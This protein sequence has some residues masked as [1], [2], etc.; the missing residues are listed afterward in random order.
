MRAIT[1]NA[2]PPS[3]TAHRLTPHCDYDNYPD[4]A[5]LRNALVTE[6]RGL[7]CYCMDRIRNET[8]SMK[9]EHWQCQAKHP[10]EHLSYRNLLGACLGGNGQPAHLQHCDTRKG[11]RD[12]L[13]NPADAAHHIETRVR[14]ELDGSI[15][16]DEAAFNAELETVLNL[17]LPLLKHNRRSVL[18]A[19]LTWWRHEKTRI[20]GAVPRATFER[21]R[22]RRTDGTAHLEPFCQVAVWWLEQRLAGMAP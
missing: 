16:S 1:K 18:D 12:L 8:T 15:R 13:W 21:E 9:I 22:A 3:L 7:C 10:G 17:N 4:K 2:E 19:V 6:Q 5:T 20:G 14:Y 11:D